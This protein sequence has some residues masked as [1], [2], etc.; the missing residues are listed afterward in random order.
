[1]PLY[2]CQ[3]LTIYNLDELYPFSEWSCVI[4]YWYVFKKQAVYL[5]TLL[6]YFYLFIAKN[7]Y[8]VLH[9]NVTQGGPTWNF[10]LLQS[11]CLIDIMEDFVLSSMPLLYE[12]LQFILQLNVPILMQPQLFKNMRAD[13][14]SM[15]SSSSKVGNLKRISAR[16]TLLPLDGGSSISDN[17]G[18]MDVDEDVTTMKVFIYK[19]SFVASC[20]M[21]YPKIVESDCKERG[22][23]FKLK[24]LLDTKVD[25]LLS[26]SLGSCSTFRCIVRSE[27]TI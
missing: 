12:H 16:A 6:I 5:F 4:S 9:L 14:A 25:E 22:L 19:E 24:P 18:S 17:E 26:G 2:F 11:S 7:H 15:W 20:W 13:L 21:L 8:V 23:L 10:I 3:R 1:M 27:K